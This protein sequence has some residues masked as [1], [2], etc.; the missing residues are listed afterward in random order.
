MLQKYQTSY[1]LVLKKTTSDKYGIKVIHILLTAFH[2]H[3][4][5][6]TGMIHTF[7]L[8]TLDQLKKDLFLNYLEEDYLD[9]L[10][11]NSELDHYKL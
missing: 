11:L 6:W 8:G 2:H 10:M 1:Q 9:L 5:S 7:D 3:G 4:G